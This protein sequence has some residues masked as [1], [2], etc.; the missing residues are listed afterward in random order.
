M[1]LRLLLSTALPPLSTR[2]PLESSTSILL[3]AGSIS[4]VNQTT[5][6]SGASSS[7][8]L[9]AGS[10]LARF[11]C[12]DADPGVSNSQ[13]K[14]PATARRKPALAVLSMSKPVTS[15]AVSFSRPRRSPR[16]ARREIPRIVRNAR[17]TTSVATP[18]IGLELRTSMG[19]SATASPN[20]ASTLTVTVHTPSTSTTVF[21]S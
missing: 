4:S 10:D 1:T 17:S 14:A 20:E 16:Y 9:A 19:N 18:A 7:T 12:A 3:K 8:S 5:T 21:T 13:N 15:P 11:A 2:D 6:R